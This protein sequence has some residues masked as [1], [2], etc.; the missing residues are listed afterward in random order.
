MTLLKQCYLD[1]LTSEVSIVIHYYYTGWPDFGVPEYSST[2]IQMILA[3]RELKPCVTVVHCSAGVG[4]TGTFLAMSRFMDEIDDNVES[5]DVFATVLNL[6]K[7]RRF[8]VR[9]SCF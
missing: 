3:L 4:R 2:L 1:T 8:M 6:R 9:F 7:D 5:I